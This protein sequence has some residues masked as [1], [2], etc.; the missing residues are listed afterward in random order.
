[1]EEQPD[2]RDRAVTEDPGFAAF[3]A[4]YPRKDRKIEARY[5]WKQAMRRFSADQ[6][7]VSAADYCAAARGPAI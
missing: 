3:W 6:I 2:E 5:E 4:I 7:V 1:M